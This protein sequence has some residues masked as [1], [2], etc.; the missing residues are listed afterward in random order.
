M[1]DPV[2]SD[3]PTCAADC[4]APAWREGIAFL[5]AEAA[6]LDRR[7]F[8][9]QSMLA[10]A[11]VALAACGTGGGEAFA[12]IDSPASIGSSIKLADF[13]SLA[14]VGG[15]ALVTLKG[16]PLAV[17]RTGTTTFLALSRVCPHEGATVNASSN[18]F[19]CPRHG[20]TFSSAGAWTGGQ[21]A[22]SLRSY[23]TTFDQAT[24]T[25]TIA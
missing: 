8:L 12:P 19:T 21:R 7:G 6:R 1:S 2:P 24:G 9:T 23:S 11:T 5:G 15:I 14:T 3:V 22:S 17:V 20:A 4:G 13:P 10:A 18:G 25:I 16:V